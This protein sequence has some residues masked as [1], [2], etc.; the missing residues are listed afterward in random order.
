MAAELVELRVMFFGDGVCIVR[1]NAHRRVNPVMLLGERNGG[2]DVLDRTRAAA[3]GEQRFDARGL[4]RS[5]I[6]VAVIVELSDSSA[7]VS[8]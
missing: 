4:A 5:S 3:D 8:R 7:H 6:A 1:V 2:I